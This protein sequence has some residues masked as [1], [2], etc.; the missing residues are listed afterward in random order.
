[1]EYTEFWTICSANGIIMDTDQMKGIK[2]YHNELLYWNSKVNL[3]S[4]KDEEHILDRHILHSL[5]ILK[6]VNPRQK[7][8]CLDIGTGGGLPGIPL[9]IARPDQ[10]MLLVDSIHKKIK[11]TEM[12]AKHTELKGIQAI[13]SR[14][15]LLE[16][17]AEYRKSFD[18]IFSRAVAKIEE[19]LSWSINL[20]KPGGSFVFLKGGQLEEEIAAAQAKFGKLSFETHDINLLG[21]NYFQ[22][23][24]KKIVVCRNPL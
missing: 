12:F 9:K 17:Q 13:C 21:C 23:E 7:S 20:I 16:S 14:V 5:S 6:Y 18:Y 3:I 2:R 4:R 10:K 8:N 22:E 19:L 11:L 24:N 15:E 1:M